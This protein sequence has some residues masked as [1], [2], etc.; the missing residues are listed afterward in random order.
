LLDLLQFDGE[1]LSPRLHLGE[2]DRLRL[3]CVEQ[4]LIL[5]LDS[6]PALEQL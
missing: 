5:S 3:I 6:L 4:S 1:F 2:V